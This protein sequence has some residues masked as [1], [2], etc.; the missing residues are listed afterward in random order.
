M[1]ATSWPMAART[2]ADAADKEIIDPSCLAKSSE[3]ST[4]HAFND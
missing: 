4:M 2:V 3:I 1:A